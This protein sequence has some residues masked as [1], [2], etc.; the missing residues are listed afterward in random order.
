M[1]KTNEAETEERIRRHAYRIWMEEGRP[2]G[3][4]RAH[5]EMARELV[6]IEDNQKFASEPNPIS[7]EPNI[8]PEGEPIEP[9]EVLD[10]LGEFPTLTDQGEFQPPHRIEQ[11]PPKP[12]SGKRAASRTPR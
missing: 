6:A 1:V 3:R 4:D 7:H 2:S 10:N 12:E 8:G 9:A 11:P 5:W